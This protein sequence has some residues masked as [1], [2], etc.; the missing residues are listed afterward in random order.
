[1]PLVEIIPGKK[2][3]SEII[4]E[5]YNFM[6]SIGK[7]AVVQRKETIGS[8]GNRLAAA[9]WR[10][11]INLVD[12]GVADLEEIDKAVSAGPG[13]RWAVIGP[14]LSYHLGGG[15]GGIEYFSR[16]FRDLPSQDGGL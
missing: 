4:K 2:T 15:R 11:A 13:L 5:T 8:I 10:E 9:L 1:M 12:E 7:V 3:S 14:H 6:T 16:T